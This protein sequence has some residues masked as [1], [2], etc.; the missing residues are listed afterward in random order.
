V[1]ELMSEK[2]RKHLIEKL[3]EVAKVLRDGKVPL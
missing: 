1:L 2:Q 3:D